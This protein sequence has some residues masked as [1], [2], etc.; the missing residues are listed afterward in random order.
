MPLHNIF[1]TPI[2]VDDLKDKEL[3]EVQH[4][5]PGAIERA[6]FTD[7]PIENHKLQTT[8]TLNCP[9]DLKR[10]NLEHVAWAIWGAMDEW[11]KSMEI[12][13]ISLEVRESWINK[14]TKGD[15]MFDHTQPT[16]IIS[17]IYFHK[18]P[19]NS[20]GDLHFRSPNLL[21]HK[22]DIWPARGNL[23]YQTQIVEAKEGR[24]VLFPSWLTHAVM[25]VTSDEEQIRINFNL[26]YP[27]PEVFTEGLATLY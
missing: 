27:T 16:G 8:Y 10:Y 1:S 6:V 25:P 26:Q 19:E 2:F 15:F 22:L 7:Y 23:K 13:P 17:G 12:D 20:G 14:F 24:I 9:S 18:V 4:A 5:I 21:M 11:F 3:E